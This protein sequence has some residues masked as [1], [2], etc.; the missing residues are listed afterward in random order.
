[1]SCFKQS[2]LVLRWLL[3]GTRMSQLVTDN[4]VSKSTGYDHVAAPMSPFGQG[5]MRLG[6]GLPPG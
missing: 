1:L 3:N 5:R 2:V 4:K 6:H